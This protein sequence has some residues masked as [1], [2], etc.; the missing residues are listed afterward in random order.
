MDITDP[1]LSQKN[2]EGKALSE[3]PPALLKMTQ[4]TSLNLANNFI[5]RIPDGISKLVDLTDL[6]VSSNRLLSLPP[7]LGFLANLRNLQLKSNAFQTPPPEV[8]SKKF[9]PVLMSPQATCHW[10][11][12]VLYFGFFVYTVR[13][14]FWVS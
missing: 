3:F 5:E 9:V 13:S 14:R 10:V 4:L 7:S 6:N 8:L 11:D 12:I 1:R 2:L